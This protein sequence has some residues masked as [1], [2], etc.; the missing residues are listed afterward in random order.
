M[1][2]RLRRICNKLLTSLLTLLGFGCT[3]AF[4][5]CYGPPP[6]EVKYMDEAEVVNSISEEQDDE[7]LVADMPAAD[8]EGEQTET[9][10]E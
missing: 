7:D 3:F 4:M 9:A 2:A 5:A 10:D 8:G 6:Q 1:K